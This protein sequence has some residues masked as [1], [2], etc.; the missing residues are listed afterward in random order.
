MKTYLFASLL[1][2]LFVGHNLV[3][4]QKRM[5]EHEDVAKWNTIKE[6]QISPDGKW[7]YYVF[8]CDDGDNTLI[9][10]DIATKKEKKILFIASPTF[11]YNSQYLIALKK[12]PLDSVRAYKRRKKKIEDIPK[13]SL[14][15]YEL[16]TEKMFTIGNIRQYKVPHKDGEWLAALLEKDAKQTEDTAQSSKKNKKKQSNKNGYSLKIIRLRDKKELSLPFV[17]EYTFSENGS[18]LLFQTTGD[19]KDFFNGVYTLD[20]TT[21]NPQSLVR[22]YWHFKNLS[23]SKNGEKATFLVEKDTHSRSQ[24]HI[25]DV[26]FWKKNRDSASV[27]IS[28]ND[29]ALP[30]KHNISDNYTPF[31]SD[32]EE[33]LFFG[34]APEP[35]RTDTS[36]LPEET[37][38]VDIWHYGEGM[39]YS[40]QKVNA[41][42]EKKKTYLAEYDLNKKTIFVMGEKDIPEIIL[43]TIGEQQYALGISSDAYEH[44]AMYEG[45]PTYKDIYVLER[46][47]KTKK[48]IASKIKTSPSVSPYGRYAYWFSHTDTAWFSYSFS[49]QKTFQLTNGKLFADEENDMPDYPAEYGIA[50]WGEKDTFVY[51]YDR[52]DIWKINPV[53]PQE[54][55]RIT[56]G[57]NNKTSHR[58]IQIN[59]EEHFI[60]SQKPMY[61]KTVQETSKRHGI[62]IVKT[63][64]T[65]FQQMI[66]EDKVI[67]FKKKSLSAD[68]WIYT[69]ENFQEYPDLLITDNSFSKSEK[70]TEINPQK[71]DFFWGTEEIVSWTS[72]DGIQLQGLLYKPENFDVKKKYPIIVYFYERESDKFHTHYTPTFG[73]SSINVTFYTSRGY[74]VFIPDISYK[75]GYPGESAYNAILPGI[76]ALLE[77]GFVDKENIG[78]QGHSW[79]G[80]QVAYLVT[81]T[82]IFKAAEAGAPVVNMFSAYG[83]IRWETGLNRAFQYEHTQSRIGGSVWQFPLRFLENSPLFWLEKIQTPLLILHNDADGHVPWYQGIELF[84]GLRRLQKPAWL[85][86]YNNQPHWPITYPNRR[87]WQ[88]RMQQYFDYYLKNQAPPDWIIRGTPAVE[89]NTIPKK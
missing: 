69:K 77:K 31:F 32:N 88:T 60:Y 25:H 61:L 70:I 81:R 42:K 24:I 13:D 40:Q 89:K 85:L 37:P 43:S 2:I 19:N 67:R 73:R 64:G 59:T 48:M 14:I 74:I 21:M 26:F 3:F 87:D 55:I 68:K 71:K 47:T 56:S 16:E 84:I 54:K 5:L 27:L 82:N 78:V 66:E 52:Y 46:E 58:Y 11:T 38:N 57:R 9:L 63:D 34:I 44:S 50:G 76:M 39:L 45:Y 72:L 4:A 20:K 23:L 30:Y 86:N 36:L 17:K 6:E 83:G 1:G 28:S 18:R 7:V 80:Y 22:N 8:G 15:V 10:R 51:I 75:I 41:E 65:N 35:F 62:A 29:P 49:K 12:F 79:G 53:N 33:K